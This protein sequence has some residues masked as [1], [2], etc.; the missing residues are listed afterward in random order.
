M[1]KTVLIC[2]MAACWNVFGQQPAAPPAAP[3]EGV[4]IRTGTQEVLLD[5]VVRDKKGQ[6]VTNLEPGELEVTDNGVVR[7]I[8]SFRLVEGDRVIAGPEPGAPPK[9]AE[10]SR[11]KRPVDV[12][13]PIRLVTLIFNR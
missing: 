11:P 13:R 1:K 10:V 5:V 8:V 2:S 6:R 12:E 4:T 7:K 3:A 9:P